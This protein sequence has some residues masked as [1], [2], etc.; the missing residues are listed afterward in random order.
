L[1]T[2]GRSSSS[3]S[4]EVWPSN[5]GPNVHDVRTLP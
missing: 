5:F 1:S 2:R 4:P 3:L